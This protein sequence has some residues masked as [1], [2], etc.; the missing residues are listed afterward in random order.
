MNAPSSALLGGGVDHLDGGELARGERGAQLDGGLQ[1]RKSSSSALTALGRVE[2]H[3]VARAVD[4]LVAPVGRDERGRAGHAGP[5]SGRRR[6]CSRARAVGRDRREARAAARARGAGA[7]SR[8]TSSGR[9]SARPALEVGDHAVGLG[10]RRGPLAQEAPSRPGAGAPRPPGTG[11]AACTRT[12]R[13]A[14]SRS[15]RPDGRRRARRAAP[16]ARAPSSANAQATPAP[17]SWP[18]TCACSIPSSSRIATRSRDAL[19]DAIGVD[20]VRLVGV[21][22]PAQVG[23]DDA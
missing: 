11:T 4:A 22:E 23:R 17:Q 19:A 21:A 7:G 15:G 3:P 5:R 6:R 18:T 12:S 14:R 2:L 13:A 10:M 1:H 9:R 20:V 8:G 16:A